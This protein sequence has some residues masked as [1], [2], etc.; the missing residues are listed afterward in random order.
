M[1]RY[2]MAAALACSLSAHAAYAGRNIRGSYH[3]D[4]LGRKVGFTVY[5]PNPSPDFSKAPFVLYLLHGPDGDEMEW[6]DNGAVKLI[7]TLIKTKSLHPMAI[8]M[9]SFGEQSWWSDGA[10]DR[11]ESALMQ[12]FM[13]HVES[14]YGWNS[15][16]TAR[17]IAGWSMGAYG[18]LN[19]ALSYPERF[20]AAGII[21]PLI[22][23]PSPR[24]ESGI[25]RTPQF[26]RNGEFDAVLWKER[27]YVSRLA[28][29]Q[30]GK[31]RVPIWIIAGDDDR[32]LGMLPM[33]TT[34]YSRILAIQP[35]E[36]ELRI[37][38]GELDWATVRKAL[39]DTLSY[40]DRKCTGK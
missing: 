20:C 29:Y 13:P 35:R 39:P 17:A 40:I 33:T 38:D 34:L 15:G 26:T 8:V 2:L 32:L 19:M 25:Q 12:E 10:K 14:R 1:K 24:R 3:S 16:H 4:V 22:D 30:G 5:L 9:P 21:S 27:H 31:D 7:D 18:A 37:I 23:D 36:A 11:A 28:A 6:L